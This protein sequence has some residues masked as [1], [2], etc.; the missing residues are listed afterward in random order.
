MAK[1][2]PTSRRT[3]RRITPAVDFSGALSGLFDLKGKTAYLPGGYGGLGEAIAWGLALRGA[4]IAV[5]GRD[6]AKAEALARRLRDAG[7]EALGLRMD[8]TRV[9][10]I[11]RSVDT[12]AKRFGTVDI[13]VNC[14]GVHIEQRLGEVTEEA[15]DRV[16]AVNLKAAMFLGQAVARK[17]VAA[18]R[19][20]K[21]IHLL[22]VRAQLGLRNRGYSS[23]CATKG[24]L[25]ML[26]KQHA[27]ELAP[28]AITVNGI[29][30]TFVY[31]EMIRHVMENPAFRKQLHARIPL[32]RIAEPK[33]I[34]GAALFFAAP[35][36]DFV[37]GQV[38]YVDGGITA[39]Q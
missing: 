32:G 35:S 27:M 26:V 38:L 14:V 23:Y 34:V 36:S 17:Q 31:T 10:D 2:R 29:A 8:A 39:S 12:V 33:D 13:L 6:A 22:S 25:V 9:R 1:K 28:H 15:F 30:P 37:T 18:S 11:E 24:G 20:G 4:K 21:Q 7:H 19:G 3:A 16:Y 5:S